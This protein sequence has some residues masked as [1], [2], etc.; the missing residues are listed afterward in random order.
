MSFL[1]IYDRQQVWTAVDIANQKG[2]DKLKFNDRVKWVKDNIDTLEAVKRQDSPWEYRKAVEALRK[3]QNKEEANHMV[4]LDASNQALQLYAVLTGDRDTAKLCNLA[5]GDE[6]ADAYRTLADGMNQELNTDIFDRASCKKALM[7][8]LYAKTNAQDMILEHL[9]P[10]DYP[11]SA[12][13]KLAEKLGLSFDA[14]R[15]QCPEFKKA[16]ETVLWRIAPRAMSAMD[17]LLKLNDE[18][19][20]QYFWTMPDGF[21]VKY[22]VKQ[23]IQIS[24]S[25]VLKSGITIGYNSSKVVYQPSDMNRGMAPNIIHSIDG[26]VAREMIR[27]MNGKFITTIHDAFACNPRD[28]DL[29]RKNYQDIMVELLHSDLLNNIIEQI[30]GKKNA[31]PKSDTLTEQDIRDSVYYLS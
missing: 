10:R 22:D 25:K 8:T 29:M 21:K 31:I 20:G 17:T 7:T 3:L 16:F 23:D 9:Y 4:Y 2:L 24:N 15:G 14:E 19:I 11:F 12:N 26:W 5:N 6:I 27:R 1:N 28:C 30:S 18:N 13:K